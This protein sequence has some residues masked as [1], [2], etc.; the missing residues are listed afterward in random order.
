MAGKGKPVGN[1][2]LGISLDGTSFGNTLDEI[3][4]RLSKPSRI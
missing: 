1:I 3:N 2:K 4:A